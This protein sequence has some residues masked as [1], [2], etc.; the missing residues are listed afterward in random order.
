MSILQKEHREASSSHRLP[1]R[2]GWG[3]VFLAKA[4][5][6]SEDDSDADRGDGKRA[7]MHPVEAVETAVS[8]RAIN[9]GGIEIVVHGCGSP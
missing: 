2:T 7:P 9:R 4:H 1:A 6:D 8:Q 3:G 5:Q